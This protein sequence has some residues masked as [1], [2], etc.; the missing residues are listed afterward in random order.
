MKYGPEQIKMIR[1]KKLSELIER[2]DFVSQ[3]SNSESILSN[4]ESNVH[5][6]EKKIHRNFQKT[7][8][9]L[10]QAINY[11]FEKYRH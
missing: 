10:K 8:S 3:Y 11:L 6:L 5:H 7:N 4:T 9:S 1:E 2:V